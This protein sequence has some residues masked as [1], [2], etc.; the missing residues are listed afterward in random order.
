MENNSLCNSEVTKKLKENFTK[1]KDTHLRNLLTDEDRNSKCV[2]S[3]ENLIF[4]FTHQKVDLESLKL[5]TNLCEERKVKEKF[6]KMYS[7][8]KINITENRSVLHTAL[9]RNV[10]DNLVVDGT[11]VMTDVH[12]V[13]QRIKKYSDQI[14]SNYFVNLLDGEKVGFTGKKLRNFISI[15]I[16]GSY[17]AGEFVYQSLKHHDKYASKAEGLNL[18]YDYINLYNIT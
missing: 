16:G 18:L 7:G 11:P 5:L 6:E 13:L 4:D 12:N 8:E 14:R 10:N 15:G 17:L 3:F 1:L 9:R 2:I